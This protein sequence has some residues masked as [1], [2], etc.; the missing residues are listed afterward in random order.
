[1]AANHRVCREDQ[2]DHYLVQVAITGC[3]KHRNQ[4][5]KRISI[6]SHTGD[7]RN[8]G[9]FP[10]FPPG[11]PLCKILEKGVGYKV[12]TRLQNMRNT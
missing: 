12:D 9:R 7:T 11:S 8:E 10:G 1:M 2:P 4:M 6:W 5:V 3:F